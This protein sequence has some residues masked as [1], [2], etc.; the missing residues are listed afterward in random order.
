MHLHTFNLLIEEP[1]WQ[2]TI[3]SV[4]VDVK[5]TLLKQKFISFTREADFQHMP[6]WGTN[7]FKV[8]SRFKKYRFVNKAKKILLYMCGPSMMFWEIYIRH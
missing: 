1:I 8:E 5:Y 4:L 7:L 6:Q 2:R 3:K